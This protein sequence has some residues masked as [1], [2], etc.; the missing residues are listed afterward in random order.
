M[1]D[2]ELSETP[3]PI[4][5]ETTATTA[6]EDPALERMVLGL[7]DMPA[8]VSIENDGFVTEGGDV[9]F[10]RDFALGN[11]TIGSPS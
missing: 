3:V 11:A 9:S 1:A 4:P 8:G 7:E 2:G 6:E 10:E 5:A